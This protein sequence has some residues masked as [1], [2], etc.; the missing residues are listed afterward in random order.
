[1]KSKIQVKE[2]IEAQEWYNSFVENL[3]KTKGN[4]CR[5]LFT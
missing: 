3:K 4:G 5:H 1:M 2:Y